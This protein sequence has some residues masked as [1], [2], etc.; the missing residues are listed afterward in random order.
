MA[1]RL[2][3][4]LT[5]ACAACATS[6][7]LER[8]RADMKAL[9]QRVESGD[10]DLAK[11][12]ADAKE[13]LHKLREAT[14]QAT[15]LLER[16]TADAG[17]QI[18]RTQ[19]DLAALQGRVDEISHQLEEIQRQLATARTIDNRPVAQALP[20]DPD[21]LFA[22]GQR[23][24]EAGRFDDARKMLRSFTETYAK[25]RRAADAQYLLG[26]SYARQ[27]KHAPAI[28][29]YQKVI[30]R[31]ARS[32]V[33]EDA[34]FKIGLSFLELK[35][36]GDARTFL[37]ETLKRYPHGKHERAIRAKLQEV[38]RNARNKRFCASS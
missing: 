5:A 15:R 29:E 4:L 24:I 16:N 35:Y 6:G 34:M 18:T 9:E 28:G 2:L 10:R 31:Y 23:A 7:D 3:V 14:E 21:S 17:L 20:A 12:S 1:L 19:T 25:D 11:A 32:P 38:E 8:V 30:D 36:C 33:L 37:S 26:E 22:E 13:Q 27:G